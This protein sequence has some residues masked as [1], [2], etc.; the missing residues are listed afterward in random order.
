MGTTREQRGVVGGGGNTLRNSKTIKVE[1]VPKI[2][3]FIFDVLPTFWL[4]LIFSLSAMTATQA[5]ALQVNRT[6]VEWSPLYGRF[7]VAGE[8][9]EHGE[10]L[11]QELPYAIGPKCNGPVLCLSCYRPDIKERCSRCGWPLCGTC[12]DEAYDQG[13]HGQAECSL[14]L[15]ARARFYEMPHGSLH[16]PQLDCIMPLRCKPQMVSMP[17]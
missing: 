12:N 1:C 9:V 7:L 3:V 13:H 10:L 8:P 4:R 16:W 15:A 6:A 2:L 14:L 5:T 11:V 17:A